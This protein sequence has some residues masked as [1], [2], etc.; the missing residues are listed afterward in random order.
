MPSPTFD[1]IIAQVNDALRAAQAHTAIAQLTPLLQRPLP[2]AQ[3]AH[4]HALLAQAYEFQSRWDEAAHLLHP[5]EERAHSA[6]LPATVHQL[7]CLRL[8]SLRTEQGDLPATVYFARQALQLAKLADDPSAQ[9]DAHQ[10]LG[11]AYR[12]LGQPAFARQHY[13]AA[14]NL[15]QT[16]GSRVLMARSYFGLGVVA[17]GSGEYALARQS[18]QCAFN[19]VG[20]ADDPLLYGLLCSMQAATLSLEEIA[21]LDERVEWLAQAKTAFEAIGHR[22]FVARTLGNWG[23]QLLRGGQWQEAQAL[24]LQSL[25]LGQELQDRRSLANVLESL[26]ELHTLQGHDEISLSYLAEALAWVE[27]HD[28]FVELQVRLALA[29]WQ[30]QQGQSAAARAAFEQVIALAR[31]TEAKQWQ[32]MAHLSL[33]EMA[34]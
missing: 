5:Y 25:A 6:A 20:E 8:A 29:R 21:P 26:A 14:L 27:G 23:D 18:L 16:L 1:D 12:L 30:W 2:A 3:R 28:H 22:R 10:M 7:L 15:H 4:A 13:Q 17:A 9:G 31:E 24:L 11:K 32:M 19:L 34:L 33:A